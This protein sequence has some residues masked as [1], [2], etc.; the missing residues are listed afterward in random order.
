MLRFVF[1]NCLGV[2]LLLLPLCTFATTPAYYHYTTKNGLIHPNVFSIVQDSLGYLWFG[3]DN[4]MSRFDGNE[5]LNFNSDSLIRQKTITNFIQYKGQFYVGAYKGELS[6]IKHDSENNIYFEPLTSKYSFEITIL[7]KDSLFYTGGGNK[8]GLFSISIKTGKVKR[9]FTNF[10]ADNNIKINRLFKLQNQRII[11]GTNK[12]FYTL[13]GD[14]ILPYLGNYFADQQ[15]AG[16]YQNKMGGLWIGGIGKLHY[17]DPS[18]QKTTYTQNIPPDKH[19]HQVLEDE[20]A[21]I[22]LSIIG[23]GLC[24]YDPTTQQLEHIGKQI[25]IDKMTIHTLYLDHEKNVWVGTESDGVYCIYNSPFTHFTIKDQLPTN[26]ITSLEYTATGEL[27]I[28]TSNGLS[29][30]KNQALEIL[31]ISEKNSV[32]YIRKVKAHPEKGIYVSTQNMEP[33][34]QITKQYKD[35]PITFSDLGYDFCFEANDK[36]TIAGY[37][38]FSTKFEESPRKKRY[39]KQGIQYLAYLHLHLTSIEKLNDSLY[40]V[41]TKQGIRQLINKQLTTAVSSSFADK[42]VEAILKSTVNDIYK[43]SNKRIW[44]ATNNGLAYYQN[45]K[46]HSFSYNHHIPQIC[47]VI[48]ED[49]QQNLWIGTEDG[50]FCFNKEQL[51]NWSIN[52]GLM[53]N[54]ISALAYNASKNQLAV[55]TINGLSLL[56]LDKTELSIPQNPSTIYFHIKSIEVADTHYFTLPESKIELPY[57][58]PKIKVQFA[59][60]HF[61]NPKDV[62]YQYQLNDDINQWQDINSNELSLSSLAPDDYTLKIRAKSPTSNWSAPKAISFNIPRPYWQN[63]F[64]ILL[65]AIA[66]ILLVIFLAYIIIQRIRKRELEKRKTVAHISE[67]KQQALSAMMNP[68]FIFNSL[69]SIQHYINKYDKEDA[70]DYL[71]RFARLIRSNMNLAEKTFIPLSEE[72]KHL[73]LYVSLEKMRFGTNLNYQIIIDPSID[74]MKVQLPAMIL[75]PYVENAI[76][77]G[78]TDKTKEGKVLL[79]IGKAAKK[80]FLEIQIEDNGIGIEKSKELKGEKNKHVSQGMR[81][82]KDRIQHLYLAENKEAGQVNIQEM[83]DEQLNILGTSVSI[84]LPIF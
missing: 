13:E 71:V 47:H 49:A 39:K 55:G 35:I 5:F 2:V 40:L 6:K 84:L 18:G 78:L 79:K 51:F 58:N 60:L 14:T 52:N 1:T 27:F 69:N 76:W 4:G 77:H 19:I 38:S 48:V 34:E 11:A 12:G 32:D 70:N 31:K 41:G 29:V 16:I 80:D 15:I 74:P 68:H 50:L 53:S 72:L 42:K 66:I 28:G 57:T 23:K 24:K 62:R 9:L 7:G 61:T 54:D 81:I 46:W 56:N 63:P 82:T 83:K 8:S 73:E 65:A 75:Q 64:F 45:H 30:Y 67:L 22:W 59:A 17:I 33:L 20:Q 37:H 36:F 10:L 21:N 26:Q 25:G 44:I 43:G 3:T